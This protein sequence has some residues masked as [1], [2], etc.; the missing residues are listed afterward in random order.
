[1]ETVLKQETL[2]H[3]TGVGLSFPSEDGTKKVILKDVN[4]KVVNLVR[5]GLVTGQVVSLIGRSGV[6]KTQILRM[7]CGLMKP[8]EG[9]IRI[10]QKQ[11]IVKPGDMG[12]V[13]QDYYMFPWRR[14]RKILELAAAKN[15][16]LSDAKTQ[17]NWVDYYIGAFEL[18]DHL[19]KFPNQL[20]GGQRQRVSISQQ[21]LNGSN[22]LL[23]DEPF[24]GLDTLMIDKTTALLSRV[25]E[26]DELKTIIIVSHDL[27]NSVAIS[28]TVFIL[29]KQGRS[30][31][32]GATI[33][34]E[35]DLVE[36]DLAWHKEIKEM[37]AF[38]ETLKEI[39]SLL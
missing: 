29:S 4:F 33:V 16:A 31:A 11:E 27:S 34:K 28:D 37:P 26:S 22:F 7:L 32:E 17:K 35:I 1:M 15:P 2:L 14:I 8:T 39:K 12:L 10:N 9:E 30:E 23:M 5:P 38:H 6:G 25:A 18:Q 13:P 3:A 19:N 21:L 24:S 36:R 20:S